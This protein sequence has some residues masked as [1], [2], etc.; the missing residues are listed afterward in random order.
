MD[1]KHRLIQGRPN[2]PPSSMSSFVRI[3]RFLFPVLAVLLVFRGLYHISGRY[4]A[5]GKQIV[6]KRLVPLEAHIISKCPDTRVRK[7]L[8]LFRSP[9]PHIG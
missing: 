1:G 9:S 7:V 6:T 5:Y 2:Q 3:R 8:W 4:T